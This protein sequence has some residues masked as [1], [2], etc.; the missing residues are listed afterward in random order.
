MVPT[1]VELGLLMANGAAGAEEADMSPSLPD[2][3][4]VRLENGKVL[5]LFWKGF[6]TCLG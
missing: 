6:V 4:K 2:V 1:E 3:T 5:E